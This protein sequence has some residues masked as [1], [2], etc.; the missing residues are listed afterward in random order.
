MLRQLPKVE[1]LGKEWFVDYRL[2]EFRSAVKCGEPI[3]FL[4]NHEMDDI[5]NM[6][7]AINDLENEVDSETIVTVRNLIENAIN[8]D[9]ESID[10]ISKL[11]NGEDDKEKR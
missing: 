2:K 8:G 6:N 3:V 7:E 1:L 5:L 9:R 4:K 11:W 10:N